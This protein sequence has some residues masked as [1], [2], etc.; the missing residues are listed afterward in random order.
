MGTVT[1]YS[2][3]T[4]KG[5]NID[6]EFI[7]EKPAGYKG[8]VLKL[9]NL[10]IDTTPLPF[11]GDLLEDIIYINVKGIEVPL[12]SP[13]NFHI[14][15]WIIAQRRQNYLKKQND[16]IQGLEVLKICDTDKLKKLTQNLKGKRRKLYQKSKEEIKEIE[17]Y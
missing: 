5:E 17:L 9:E 10:N 14:H 8:K 3:A 12:P 13:E 16:L 7:I 15:K 11:V 6:I 1:G 4:F 2:Y